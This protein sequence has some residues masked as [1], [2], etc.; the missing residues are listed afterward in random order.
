MR[1]CSWILHVLCSSVVT[2]AY[3]G[4]TGFHLSLFVHIAQVVSKQILVNKC[5]NCGEPNVFVFEVI[6]KKPHCESVVDTWKPVLP[7][8]NLVWAFCILA[9]IVLNLY[10]NLSH[11]ATIGLIPLQFLF[12]CYPV[13]FSNSWWC[14]KGKLSPVVFSF[15]LPFHQL[16]CVYELCNLSFIIFY[17]W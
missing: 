12:A 4:P 10:F 11:G 1:F 15:Y 13:A 3:M 2:W 14:C 8:V 6:M 16:S 7:V 9:R 17:Y 5:T